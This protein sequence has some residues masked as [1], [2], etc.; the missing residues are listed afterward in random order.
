[1]KMS[2]AIKR[3]VALGTGVTMVGAT[4]LGAMA[5]ADLGNYPGP[6][7][8]NGA[9]NALIVVG[10]KAKTED[11]LGS[12][13]IATSLQYANRITRTIP[14]TTATSSIDGEGV[15][16]AT[17]N[18]KLQIGELL[19]DVNTK[20][21][22]SELP[23]LLAKGTFVNN[24]DDQD[25]SFEYTQKLEFAA[26]PATEPAVWFFQ[27]N[28]YED[29]DNPYVFLYSPQDDEFLTYTMDFTKL[30]ESKWYDDTTCGS[31]DELCDFEGT[32]I[33]ILGTNYEITKAEYDGVS[34]L[35]WEM[36]GGTGL[37]SMYEGETKTFTI[38]GVDY[39]VT[40][41]I[42]SD[43]G[44]DCQLTVNGV[45][46]KELQKD[47]TTK[48]AGI[49][50][51]IKK[52]MPNEAGEEGAGKDLVQFYLGANKVTLSD[53]V[54]GTLSDYVRLGSTDVED[55]YVDWT[56]ED[57]TIASGDTFKI[58]RLVLTWIPSETDLLLAPG[59]S[60]SFPGFGSFNVAFAGLTAPE[61][62]KIYL[63]PSGD[64]N[65]QLKAPLYGGDLSLNILYT[66]G[67]DYLSLGN[68]DTAGE[69]VLN[70]VDATVTDNDYV[71]LSDLDNEESHIVKLENVDSD[72][73]A[74][75]KDIVSGTLYEKDC[76][77]GCTISVGN[78]DLV[79][80]GATDASPDTVDVAGGDISSTI[81]TDGGMTISLAAA[82]GVG[83]TS[84]D[85]AFQEANE[86]GEIASGGQ[87]EVT[88]SISSSKTSVSAVASATGD[89]LL[90]PINSDDEFEL[91]ESDKFVSMTAYGTKITR[92]A[93][94]DQD[95]VLI[96]YPTE[97]IHAEVFVN[98]VDTQITD[99]EAGGATYGDVQR[100]NVGAAVLDTEV[101]NIAA[102][103][104]IVVGGPC[105]NT[106]AAELMGNPA[107]CAAGFE[108]GKAMIKL[109]DQSSGKV[110]MLVAGYSAMDTRRASRV[111]ANYEQ[112]SNFGGKELEVTGTSLSDI[113]VGAPVN[114]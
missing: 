9:F 6:F 35:D 68:D 65:V 20:I 81:Y 76:D 113:K 5:A 1:M 39:E 64:D 102:Q 21:D 24:G 52:L 3:I 85:I 106:L 43:T 105:V 54:T 110:A 73:I 26:S 28:D 56:V 31:A 10:S 29:E 51:G 25:D 70:V 71:L 107:D 30:A 69:G 40:V 88:A 75:F 11:V 38:D 63:N 67:T 91:G 89:L 23:S 48:V 112:H 2:K 98:A 87:F 41:D 95:S 27:S 49:E 82:T 59:D 103:N 57:A 34:A 42:I 99:G 90:S 74:R 18:N 62:E 47:Q 37:Y 45:T 101:A 58:Q 14:G 84:F 50:I 79:L 12:I 78:T 19:D 111:V 104:V 61:V 108:D 17:T 92:D 72:G 15:K 66:D 13:D 44:L 109:F 77:A 94:G 83:V 7:V 46:T 86:Y 100:I 60:A 16:I 93:S 53:D 114:N 36:M 32:K 22:D 96:E 55:L 80:T 4:I 33:E 97:E 8:S